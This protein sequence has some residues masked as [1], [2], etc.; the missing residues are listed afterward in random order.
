VAAGLEHELEWEQE[1]RRARYTARPP[2]APAWS[3][4][5]DD[6]RAVPYIRRP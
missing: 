3:T 5:W 1:V 2:L 6:V 4:C